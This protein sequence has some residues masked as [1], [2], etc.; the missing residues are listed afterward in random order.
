M[1]NTIMFA[2]KFGRVFVNPAFGCASKCRFCYIEEL[3]FTALKLSPFS[4]DNVKRELLKSPRF[5]PG[6]NGTLISISPDTEPFDKRVLA[7]TLEFIA[8]LSALGNPM[9][10]ATRRKI[11]L[12]TIRKIVDSLEYLNQLTL[13]VSNSTITYHHIIEPGTTTPAKRFETFRICQEEGLSS[14][15]YLKP[16][17]PNVTIQDV[18]TYIE[19]INQ[20]AIQYCCIG[21]LYANNTLLRQMNSTLHKIGLPEID[22]IQGSPSL[23]FAEDLYQV[24]N[25]ED[26]LELEAALKVAACITH[27]TSSCV[28]ADILNIPS[29]QAAWI[30]FPALCIHCQNCAGLARSSPPPSLRVGG[31]P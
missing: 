21:V 15:L 8:S 4:G 30:K 28:V 9:Q 1:E 14:C 22:A 25:I 17:I 5:F 11:E 26:V 7:K 24:G 18:D 20:Y 6:R 19:V 23:P 31:N 16:V 13:F 27:R 3:G 29:A 12:D 2:E 10:I